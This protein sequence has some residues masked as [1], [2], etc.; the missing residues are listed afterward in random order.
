MS[1]LVINVGSEAQEKRLKRFVVGYR[2][3]LLNKIEKVHTVDLRY[4][5]GFAVKWKSDWQLKQDARKRK[6]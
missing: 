5:N 6:G 2:K 3:E 1:G 4:T